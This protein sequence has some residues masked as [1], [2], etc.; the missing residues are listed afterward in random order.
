MYLSESVFCDVLKRAD[1][2][3]IRLSD[4][5]SKIKDIRVNVLLTLLPTV[6]SFQYFRH[7]NDQVPRRSGLDKSK[8][9]TASK[10]DD[11]G[12]ACKSLSK[13]QFRDDAAHRQDHRQDMPAVDGKL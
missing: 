8:H 1:C 13:K 12:H 7:M 3:F 11:R 9:C 4:S 5:M 10:H 2:A 6:F